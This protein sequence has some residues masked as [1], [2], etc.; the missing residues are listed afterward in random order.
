MVK[1][2]CRKWNIDQPPHHDQ[3]VEGFHAWQCGEVSRG[4]L[5]SLTMCSDHLAMAQNPTRTREHQ[6]LPTTIGSKTGGE[7]TNPNQNGTIA[8]GS[9]TGGECTYQPKWVP[10]TVLTTTAIYSLVATLEPIPDALWR[11]GGAPSL[12]ENVM[13]SWGHVFTIAG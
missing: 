1:T 5:L 9:K 12:P 2:G 7:F 10:K 4:H 6:K 11:A 3:Q 13:N 8:T